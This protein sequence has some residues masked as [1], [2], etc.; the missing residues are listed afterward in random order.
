VPHR[1]KILSV[2]TCK[3]ISGIGLASEPPIRIVEG[4]VSDAEGKPVRQ[5]KVMFAPPIAGLMLRESA[6]ATIDESGRYRVEVTDFPPYGPKPLPA[7]GPLKFVVLS[8][9]FKPA[10]GSVEAGDGPSKVDV[11]L[12]PEPWKTTD[13]VLADRRGKPAADGDVTVSILSPA[14]PLWS[15]LKPDAEGRCRIEM[16][17][18]QPFGVEIRRE[19]SPTLS[20]ALRGSDN[21]PS[22]IKVTLREPIRGRV[23]DSEGKPVPGVRIGGWIGPDFAPDGPAG[24]STL[25]PTLSQKEVAT[26]DGEGRFVLSPSLRISPLRVGASGEFR[27]NPQRLCFADETLRR[28]AF[29]D[30]DMDI[31]SA[32]LEVTLR[33]TRLVSI[34]VE[35]ASGPSSGSVRINWSL[36]PIVAPGQPDGQLM[37]VHGFQDAKKSG[38]GD[39]IEVHCPPGRYK[40]RVGM[41][42][43]SKFLSPPL[44]TADVELVV[45]EGEGPFE[46]PT[47]RL[48]DS[49]QQQMVGRPAPE[50]EATDL[51]TGRPIKL[52]DFRGKV[53]VIDFWGYWCGPCVTTMPEMADVQR[54]FEGKP[55]LILAL[56]DQSIQSR[57]EYDQ[58]L[59]AVKHLLWSD[60]DLSLRI[61]LDRPDPERDMDRTTEANGVTIRRYQVREFPTLVVIDQQKKVASQVKFRDL[62]GLKT[63]IQQLLDESDRAKPK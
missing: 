6:T 41:L 47:A 55:V 62:D 24:P 54:H 20:F 36:T 26:T 51:E 27:S 43:T 3:L 21:E 50:I 57:E 14:G 16:A 18:N 60:K 33:S 53:V 58:R 35:H 23:V 1:L 5:G 45:P 29:L 48:F 2:I 44:G 7:S 40:F 46:G 59:K 52:A 61:A 9:G 34:A 10:V 56:H 4:R 38:E 30:V 37:T 12:E 31:P 22:G 11:K 49:A 32:P 63:K 39:R 15:K 8:P 19:G 17:Q 42:E 13:L 25:R 28:L